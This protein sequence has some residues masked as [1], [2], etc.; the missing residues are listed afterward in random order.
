MRH[1]GRW[2]IALF[3][4]VSCVFGAISAFP[5][6]HA[7]ETYKATAFPFYSQE[8]SIITL[9]LS[10]SGATPLIAY[11][12]V[13]YIIDPN[14]A[15]CSSINEDHTTG[16]SETEFGL[17]LAFPGPDFP[18]LTCS[19]TSLVGSYRVSVNQTKPVA[20]SNVSPGVYFLIG[21]TDR[22]SYQRTT[23]VSILATGYRSLEPVTVVIRTTSSLTLILSDSIFA[24][25]S[26]VVVDSWKVPRNAT[27]TEQYLVTVTGS[28]TSKN[29]SDAEIIAVY[30]AIMSIT[31]ITPS[32]SSYQ[33]TQT[34]DFS[35]QAVYPSGEFSDT[36]VGLVT[37]ARPSGGNITLT[38]TYD[39]LRQVLVAKYKT[40]PTNQTGTW[41]ASLQTGAFDD[42]WGNTGPVSP[43][44]AT[45]QLQPATFSVSITVKPY[46]VVNEQIRFNATLQYPDGTAFSSGPAYAF[47]TFIG[48]AYN[49]S[50]PVSYDSTLGLWEGAYSPN[51]APGGL[52]ALKVSGVDSASPSNSGSS[53]RNITL[54]D[55]PPVASFTQSSTN[56]LTNVIVNFDGSA[57]NDPDGTI[58]S[59]SWTFGDGSTGSGHTVSH[60][61]AS[62]GT[63]T[64]RLNVTDNSGSTALASAVITVQDRPPTIMFSLSTNS[65]TTGTVVTFNSAGTADPDGVIV[66]YTWDFGDGSFGS[67]PYPSHTYSSPGTYTVKLTVVDDSNSAISAS[68]SIIVRAPTT[69]PSGTSSVP[70]YWFGI[71]IAVIAGMLGGGFF[72]F[73][74][75][76]VTHANLK[77]DLE[78]VRS[79]AGRIESQEF[80]QSVKDQL[81]K[82]REGQ[83]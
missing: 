50:I 49:Y 10:V 65:T 61:Y 21:I 5:P 2:K 78:A 12:F 46:F 66:S 82:D 53:T 37:L 36:G 69:A 72:Y 13:F 83:E 24:D 11:Q 3:L 64:V 70:L 74:R 77:I 59:Y 55:R 67:G 48:Q 79:E 20:K 16:V 63:F 17:I 22:G 42:G 60:S 33:R 1:T 43:V 38:A 8:G 34:M 57:S 25:P 80:F 29:P 71:L 28:S 56:V 51:N 75:H 7:A 6:V 73:R 18:S 26:G 14:N 47:M 54:Q 39:S 52:W 40:T 62:A 23:T 31:G 4:A 58:I 15:I 30:P 68:S 76:R 41:T 81:K 32:G 45:A 19:Q 44:A 35:F 27:T 9:V